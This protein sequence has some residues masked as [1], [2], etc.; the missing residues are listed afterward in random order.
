MKNTILTLTALFIG[1]ISTAQVDTPFDKK[2]FKEQKDA[3]KV[4]QKHIEEGDMYYMAYS[5]DYRAAVSEYLQANAFNPN[6]ADL[7]YKIGMCYYNFDK[8]K[9]KTYFEKAYQL[10]PDRKSVV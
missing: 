4:A 10:K 5:K 1:L 8:Y 2:L 9:M 3:F 6:S 7:N